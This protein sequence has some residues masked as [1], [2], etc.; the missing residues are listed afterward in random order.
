MYSIEYN[1]AMFKVETTSVFDAWIGKLDKR[2]AARVSARLTKLRFGLWGDCKPVGGK[3]IELR[4]H[5]GAGYRLYVTQK[6]C[7]LIVALA[8]GNKATQKR[9]IE[10]AIKMAVELQ[11]DKDQN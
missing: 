11:D 3:V 4:E 8:G 6:G 10:T 2:A 7:V 5:F 9:D 1:S